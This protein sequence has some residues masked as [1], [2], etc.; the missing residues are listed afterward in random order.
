MKKKNIFKQWWFWLVIVL[1]IIA[2]IA[3]Y[4]VISTLT[5]RLF[6]KVANAQDSYSN[7]VS[8]SI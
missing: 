4:Y 2:V 7:E 5:G 3:I 1:S 8:N 6:A